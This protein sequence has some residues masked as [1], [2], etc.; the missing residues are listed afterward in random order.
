M[1]YWRCRARIRRQPYHF[2]SVHRRI[3]ERLDTAAVR[4]PR[5]RRYSWVAAVVEPLQSQPVRGYS[6]NWVPAPPRN[7][8]RTARLPALRRHTRCNTPLCS[9]TPVSHR[10]RDEDEAATAN[11]TGGRLVVR[12]SMPPYDAEGKGRGNGDAGD[13]TDGGRPDAPCPMT[14]LLGV[15][16]ALPAPLAADRCASRSSSFRVTAPPLD[17]GLAAHAAAGAAP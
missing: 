3:Q 1:G 5:E 6:L 17:L 13:S 10:L 16:I 7:F 9:C 4:T 12:R 15:P 8:G 14:T 11:K 2:S